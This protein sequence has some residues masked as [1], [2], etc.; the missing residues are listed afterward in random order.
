[1]KEHNLAIAGLGR[2]GTCFLEQILNLDD[3]RIG[4]RCVVE[5]DDTA[6]KLLALEK[7][8]DV[9]DSTGLVELGMSIDIVFDFTGDPSF[10]A[11]L[12]QA[13]K[14]GHNT[15]TAVC[16]SRIAR[17][18]WTLISEEC[19][20]EVRGSKYQALADMLLERACDG[21]LPEETLNA[22]RRL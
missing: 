16:P 13:L 19:L 10:S 8:I 11:D 21:E 14:E 7:G 22:V 3:D 6:G 9:V 15:H 18:I 12:Q 1:M 5:K 4:V 17:L 2:V 20:P